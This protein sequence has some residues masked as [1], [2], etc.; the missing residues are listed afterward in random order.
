LLVEPDG[1][2]SLV[3]RHGPGA[4]DAGTGEDAGDRPAIQVEGLGQLKGPLAA[5]IAL[6]QLDPLIVSQ[7]GLQVALGEQS[8]RGT[9]LRLGE[10]QAPKER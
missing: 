4:P 10:N 5:H 2:S 3:V 1:F 7:M 6:Q 8:G 9:N